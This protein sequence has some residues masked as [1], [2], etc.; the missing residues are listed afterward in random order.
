MIKLTSYADILWSEED[1]V[2]SSKNASA[3]GFN[4]VKPAGQDHSLNQPICSV[5]GTNNKTT[6]VINILNNG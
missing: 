2:T 3:G 6:E 5:L 1:C 4:L